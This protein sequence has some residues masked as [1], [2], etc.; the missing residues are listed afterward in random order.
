MNGLNSTLASLG[1][2]M[3]SVVKTIIFMTN[4]SDFS[5]MNSVYVP[6]FTVNS[7]LPARSTVQVIWK[8]FMILTIF[9]HA[10]CRCHSHAFFK[11][12]L[13][14]FAPV[15]HSRTQYIVNGSSCTARLNRK[16]ADPQKSEAM[17]MVLQVASL[18][19]TTQIE[20][21]PLHYISA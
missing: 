15:L 16:P 7:T 12:C 13:H 2:T 19:G 1:V 18:V 20:V 14:L 6:Y 9:F 8:A 5:T 21:H 11:S 4:V 17:F 10:V 3:D